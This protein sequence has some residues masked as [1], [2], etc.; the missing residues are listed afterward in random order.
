MA[1]PTDNN[2]LE[3]AEDHS[4]DESCLAAKLRDKV[5]ATVRG[6]PSRGQPLRLRD[7]FPELNHPDR[8]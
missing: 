8:K 6:R 1:S 7:F 5:R 4:E 3:A 2:G